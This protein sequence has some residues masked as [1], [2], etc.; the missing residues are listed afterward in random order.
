MMGVKMLSHILHFLFSCF[1]HL[2]FVFC[3]YLARYIQ[4]A[5]DHISQFV[6]F[7]CESNHVSCLYSSVCFDSLFQLSKCLIH[8]SIVSRELRKVRSADGD[9]TPYRT[10]PSKRDFSRTYRKRHVLHFDANKGCPRNSISY[11]FW[12]SFSCSDSNAMHSHFVRNQINSKLSIRYYQKNQTHSRVPHS[13]GV[14][15]RS[16]PHDWLTLCDDFPTTFMKSQFD[17]RRKGCADLWSDR[18]VLEGDC[19]LDPIFDIE[20]DRNLDTFQKKTELCLIICLAN[21]VGNRLFASSYLPSNNHSNLRQIW[22]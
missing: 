16:I 11:L 22:D 12:P 1:L 19:D 3:E 15:W 7:F 13:Y 20:D 17:C 10:V 8:S 5:N 18:L 9:F 14:H 6:R 4:L 21:A 2:G